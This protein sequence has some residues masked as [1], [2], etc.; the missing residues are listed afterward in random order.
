[1]HMKPL[2][3]MSDTEFES[4]VA[5]ALGLP[6]APEDWVVRAKRIWAQAPKKGERTTAATVRALARQIVA[7]LSFDSWAQ[8]LAAAGV[9]STGS[10][11]RHLLFEAMGR[12]I[13]LRI[14]AAGGHY[15]LMGQVLG[16]DS[17]GTVKLKSADTP[18]PASL[19]SA[20]MNELGEFA[21]HDVTRGTYE[22][23]L[24]LDD[25]EIL[26]APVEVGLPG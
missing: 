26:V 6:D 23:R 16:P 19:F 21:L 9:R 8:P 4:L 18:A 5:E 25:E 12:D 2:D 15:R 7:T 14:Q 11:V 3:E 1:M 17:S 20:D 22:L 24:E 13:D 10:E